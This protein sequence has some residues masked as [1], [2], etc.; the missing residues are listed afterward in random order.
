MIAMKMEE[1]LYQLRKQRRY[2]QEQLA[3][4]IGVSRQAISKWERGESKPDLDNLAALAKLYQ[5]TIE[6][7]VSD[8]E[9]KQEKGKSHKD[10]QWI[11]FVVVLVVVAI[12]FYFIGLKQNNN[13]KEFITFL[14]SNGIIEDCSISKNGNQYQITV[15]PAASSEDYEG[16][17]VIR[18]LDNNK[19]TIVQ[20]VY[21]N[22][23]YT[24][25]KFQLLRHREYQV[26][27]V[28]KSK[29]YERSQYVG[30]FSETGHFSE[31]WQDEIFY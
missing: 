31:Y 15:V 3:E 30:G 20:A 11:F 27:F 28:M 29:K 19:A 10:Y 8:G 21:E 22:H 12:G 6:S 5:I 4:L 1:K 13:E 25:E 23:I 14:Q 16:E 18:N 9:I 7:L 24:S 26:Y 2:S 17:F